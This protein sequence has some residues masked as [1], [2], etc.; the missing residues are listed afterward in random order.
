MTTWS[1][2]SPRYRA[3]LG[4]M[5]LFLCALPGFGGCQGLS[6]SATDKSPSEALSKAVAE[7]PFPSA[8]EAGL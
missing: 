3:T 1:L 5:L 7:D 2:S 8:A 4:V 6:T